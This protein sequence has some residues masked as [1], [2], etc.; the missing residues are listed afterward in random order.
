MK[1]GP[2][3]GGSRQDTPMASNAHA[4]EKLRVSRGNVERPDRAEAYAAFR[5][6]LRWTGDATA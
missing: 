4:L 5:T 3:L 6:I 1:C 2:A